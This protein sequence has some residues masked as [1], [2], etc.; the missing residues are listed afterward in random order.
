MRL[1]EKGVPPEGH[2]DPVD[3]KCALLALPA[4]AKHHGHFECR[5][6]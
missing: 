3:G 1:A 2:L 6:R 5:L 4:L